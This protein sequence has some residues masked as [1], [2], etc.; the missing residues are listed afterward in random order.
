MIERAVKSVEIQSLQPQEII[1]VID[2]NDELFKTLSDIYPDLKV[3]TNSGSRGL[4]G[5]RN[6]GVEA[7]VGDI[8]AF[9]DDD[10]CAFETWLENL[11][12][13][14]NDP[15]VVAT[16]GLIKPDFEAG[17]PKWLP[18]EFLWTVGCS[19]KGL[20]EDESVIRNP[21]GA[22]MAYRR[23]VLM[24]S[25]L[26]DEKIGRIGSSPLGCEETELAI[27]STNLFSGAKIIY[28][29]SSLVMHTVTVERAKVRYFLKRCYMEGISKALV[30]SRVGKT[31]ALESE[32]QY[33]TSTLPAGFVA[34]M[35]SGFRGSRYDFYKAAF[36]L[37]G[38]FATASGYLKEKIFT[39]VRT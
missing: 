35:V 30:A 3:L 18:E 22:S 16:G 24:R 13:P 9:L 12:S 21:I 34:Y 5:A 8:I 27:R 11:V 23:D 20:P 39:T 26:F 28:V 1:L 17:T 31:K 32:K 19:Y 10:A 6:S 25:G 7:S 33:A 38:F 4:S 37:G 2:H 29:P 14:F 15:D 36:I